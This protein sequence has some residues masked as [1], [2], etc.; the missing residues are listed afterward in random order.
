MKE[1][2]T[3]ADIELLKKLTEAYPETV[4]MTYKGLVEW[5]IRKLIVEKGG[6]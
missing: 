6:R 1:T 2:R 3:Y 4:G 5:A